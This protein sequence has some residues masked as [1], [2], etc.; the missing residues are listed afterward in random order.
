M[1]LEYIS[2]AL[3][4]LWKRKLRSSLTLLGV[5][6]AVA[7]LFVLVSIS[8]G[9]QNAVSEQFREL[10]T[11]KFFIFPK[12]QPAGPGSGGAVMMTLADVEVIDKVAG[13]KDLSYAVA[14]NAKVE[15][16][17]NIRYT[18]VVGIPTE[19]GDVFTESGAYKIDE[20][21]YL[22]KGDRGVIAL[23]YNFKGDSFFAKSVHAGDTIKINELEFKVK[24]IMS[25]RGN[26]G[27]DRLILMPLEDFQELF[28]SG[29]RIDQVIVQ[30]ESTALVKEV[31]ERVEKKLRSA[32]RVN[33]NTQDFT[34]LT[35]EELL[36]SFGTI[37][38]ILTS[39]LL[40]VA[41]ISLLV[42]AIGIATTMYTS[43]L[44][45]T[46][47]IGVMKA[48]GARNRDVLSLFLIESALLGLIG[49]ILGVLLGVIISKSI[50]YIA[51]VQLSTT[52][53]RAAFPPVFIVGC[54]VFASLVGAL[55]GIWPAWRAF[56]LKAVDALRY[57]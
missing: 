1:K 40:G 14:G 49:G 41:G 13:V 44:E 46:R 22:K 25:Y 34:I 30:A 45:R 47:D 12:G 5:V 26:P 19:R 52:L 17:D 31:A 55:S 15:F 20:G 3:R 23:G 53:L 21:R 16:M 24:A 56:R 6:I 54:L 36:A 43:V 42:G 51:T 29:E 33:E 4:T 18:Q 9:L 10:G 27:D 50:E 8:L 2:L 57:E 38:T 28:N 48:V 37:L 11:D 7:T 39:F 32:R 35:P